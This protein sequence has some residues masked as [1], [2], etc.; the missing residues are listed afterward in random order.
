MLQIDRRVP[1]DY[2]GIT[3]SLVAGTEEWLPLNCEP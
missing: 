3:G 2:L 1:S